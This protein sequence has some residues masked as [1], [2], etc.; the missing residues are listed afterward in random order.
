[1]SKLLRLWGIPDN[2]ASWS[3]LLQLGV[4]IINTDTVA[5]CR[6]YFIKARQ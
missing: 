5:D 1:M 3:R 2:A 4:D 6:K